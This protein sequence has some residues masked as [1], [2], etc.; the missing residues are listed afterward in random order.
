MK[1]FIILGWCGGMGG[2]HIYT[3]NQCVVA[4]KLGWTPIVIHNNPQ[5]AVISD[6]TQ[7]NANRVDEMCLLPSYYSKEERCI[8]MGK[9]L[10]IIEPK[11][12]DEFFV[13]SNGVRYSYWGELLAEKLKCKHFAFLLESYFPVKDNNYVFYSFK[14]KRKELAGIV[15]TSL[16]SLFGKHRKIDESE[17]KYIKAYCTNSVEDVPYNID[18]D[19]SQYDI[20]I[21][22]I[23]RS[24]KPYVLQV[25]KDLACYSQIHI[26]KRFLFLLVGGGKGTTNEFSINHVLSGCE[27]VD[28]LSTGSIFPIPKSLLS[29]IDVA[30]ATSGCIRIAL[31]ANLPTVAY[32][33]NEMIP[34]GIC[35]YDIKYPLPEQPEKKR[36]L[37]EI[38][39]D[40]LFNDYCKKKSYTPYFNYKSDS[41]SWSQLEE[42]TK[43]MMSAPI[44][45][46]YYD[47]SK[48]YPSQIM[49]RLYVKTMGKL[50]PFHFVILLS[51]GV[52]KR[53]T[54][55]R[56]LL[57]NVFS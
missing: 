26:N 5:E 14:L 29:H 15:Q 31:E 34:Y 24:S 53:L 49:R 20:V 18:V 50:I 19:F 44:S 57:K 23:G 1:K 47:T 52:N 22:N 38:L 28:I 9:F 43:Y 35:G 11:E 27:N 37:G 45:F 30:I 55:I 10:S 39:D 41:E 12:E 40:I 51:I 17:N 36:T 25:A 32:K 46:E 54:V 13:E 2:G 6:L 8:V 33:D 3:R 56:N 48:V 16:P 42:D 21:G 4:K 7:F